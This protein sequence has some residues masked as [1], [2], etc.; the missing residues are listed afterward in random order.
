MFLIIGLYLT[1]TPMITT[2][3]WQITI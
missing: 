1:S 2:E 3:W